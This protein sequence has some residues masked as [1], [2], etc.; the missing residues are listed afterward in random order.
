MVRPIDELDR[1]IIHLLQED[2]R[3]PS[4]EIARRLGV[5][6]RTVRAR[7]NRLVQDGVIKLVAIVNPSALGHDVTAD[8]FL[9][10]EPGR[11][12]EVA[13]KLVEMEEVAY[14]GLTTG[15]RDI[16]IQV[17]VP[18]VD[19]LYRFITEKL[20]RI[21]GVVGTTTYV[22]PRVL[23]WLHNWSLPSESGAVVGR[24][25]VRRRRRRTLRNQAEAQVT[26]VSGTGAGGAEA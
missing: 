9:E 8:I 15:D 18:S 1:Q 12:E 4:A 7:I 2:S 24:R 10:V 3:M 20:Q 14:V 19:A 26:S 23:K 22:V 25:V 6:E 21:P 16:S 11:L 5:A 13:H 17:F